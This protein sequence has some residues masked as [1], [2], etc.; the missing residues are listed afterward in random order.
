M[1]VTENS[2]RCWHTNI[3]Y[4]ISEKTSMGVFRVWGWM[5]GQVFKLWVLWQ[6]RPWRTHAETLPIMKS[7]QVFKLFFFMGD[8]HYS[9]F[10]RWL[11]DDSIYIFL[12]MIICRISVDSSRHFST[13]K[14]RR[15]QI[16]KH[17]AT[18]SVMAWICKQG[19]PCSECFF[20]KFRI[21]DWRQ[22]QNPSLKVV[23]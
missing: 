15:L 19:P 11:V 4:R 5:R 2:P 7:V 22:P 12:W 20:W 23:T 21:N 14:G 1:Q 13:I 18:C 10:R 9:L 8:R 16:E 6:Y 17:L 3:P